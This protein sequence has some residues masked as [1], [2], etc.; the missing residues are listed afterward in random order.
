MST[1]NTSDTWTCAFSSEQTQMTNAIMTLLSWEE[2]KIF[3]RG[4]ELQ[5]WLCNEK[6]RYVGTGTVRILEPKIKFISRKYKT[7]D[8][9]KRKIKIKIKTN[10]ISPSTVMSQVTIIIT[11]TNSIWTILHTY[12]LILFM[13]W[14][15]PWCS[16][17]RHHATN[18][19]IARS[20]PACI[21]ENFHLHNPSG[22]TM[23][24]GST[25]SLKHMSTRNT[26]WE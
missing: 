7:A 24:L 19:K 20:T 17:L 23:A 4:L 16:W 26:S 25:Q 2:D 11:S 1:S 21:I 8:S 5:C 9:L 18:R 14:S 12:T 13:F 3:G 22:R 6:R 15:T 10:K